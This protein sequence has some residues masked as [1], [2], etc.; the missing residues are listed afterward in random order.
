MYNNELYHFG[1]KG[2]KWGVRRYQ[3]KYGGLTP[4]G[5]MRMRK[6]NKLDEKDDKYRLYRDMSNENISNFSKRKDPVSRLLVKSNTKALSKYEKTIEK[7]KEKIQNI[8]KELKDQDIDVVVRYNPYADRMQYKQSDR[9][10]Q[11]ARDNKSLYNKFYADDIEGAIK[12]MSET[13]YA[14]VRKHVGKQI[15]NGDWA[16][17]EEYVIRKYGR[18]K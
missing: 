5:K 7:N 14:D 2:M 6:L 8:I 12:N 3:N 18:Q 1:V 13:Q 15:D 17:V 11:R 9:Q 10:I 4:A 16:D